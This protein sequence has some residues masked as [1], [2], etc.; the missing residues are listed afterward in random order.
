MAS[1]V[2]RSYRPTDH[3]TLSDPIN[4]G[5]LCSTQKGIAAVNKSML[6]IKRMSKQPSMHNSLLSSQI[7]SVTYKEPPP[8]DPKMFKLLTKSSNDHRT[9]PIFL[10]IMSDDAAKDPC[11][12][13]KKTAGKVIAV[14]GVFLILL[15][16]LFLFGVSSVIIDGG[17][18]GASI[19]TAA[20]LLTIVLGISMY[21]KIGCF[22]DKV[23]G[24]PSHQEIDPRVV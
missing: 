20:G 14:A 21:K 18:I 13:V 16:V 15:A 17:V 5:D 2:T 19:A 22:K 12:D 4:H 8:F 23:Q 7:I 10:E 3:L 24:S 9:G 11:C 1:P 6:D